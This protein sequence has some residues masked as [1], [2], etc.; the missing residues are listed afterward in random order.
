MVKSMN[1]ELIK[2]VDSIIKDQ[3]EKANEPGKFLDCDSILKYP[4]LIMSKI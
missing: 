1:N 3:I 2:E 4:G